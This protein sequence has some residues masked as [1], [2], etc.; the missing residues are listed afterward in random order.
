MNKN[1]IKIKDL[2]KSKEEFFKL[3]IN[4]KTVYILNHY[5]R[6]SKTYSISPVED[7]NK[8]SFIKPER[9]IYIG[10]TY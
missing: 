9:Y 1:S 6:S 7:F 5:D 3:N 8:E 4:S 10:F 2:K